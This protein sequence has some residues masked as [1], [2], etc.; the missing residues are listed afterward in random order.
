MNATIDGREAVIE[1]IPS[2]FGIPKLRGMYYVF[3]ADDRGGYFLQSD[4]TW[5]RECEKAFESIRDAEQ[6]MARYATQQPAKSAEGAIEGAAEYIWLHEFKSAEDIAGCLRKR[7]SASPS[8]WQPIDSAPKDGTDFLGCWD[9]G[10]LHVVCIRDGECFREMDK[11]AWAMPVLWQPLPALPEGEGE[12]CNLN[13]PVADFFGPNF[14]TATAL[15][16]RSKKAA[17]RNGPTCGLAAMIRTRNRSPVTEP[18][19]TRIH[20]RKMFTA[21][22][23]CT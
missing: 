5:N 7:L 20:C 15:N 23:E 18:A 4:G 2:D 10:E 8:P 11:E 21:Q 12:G 3:S 1:Q 22:R 6:F 16:A 9:D 14:A 13:Q 17:R 19:G